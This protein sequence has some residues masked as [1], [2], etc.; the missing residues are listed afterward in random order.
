MSQPPLAK[1]PLTSYQKR[2]LVFLSVATFFEG[3]DF[4][5]LTQI[6][7]NLRDDMNLSKTEAGIM[8]AVINAGTVLAYLLIRRADSWGRKRVLA[9]TIAGYT[10]A[11][12]LSG[13]APEAISFT[14]FQFFARTFL[15]AEWAISMVYAA[16]EYPADRRGM[17][18]GVI[19]A[20]SSLGS[21]MCAGVVPLLLKTTYGWRTVFFVGI[22]PLVLLAFARRNIKET[23]RFQKKAEDAPRKRPSMFA[24][25]KTPYRKRV[26]QLGLIWS[27]TYMCNQSAVTFWKDFAVN[28]RGLSDSDV[29]QA[30]TVAAIA[31]MPM[32]FFS[33]KLLDV[34]G[35]RWGAVIIYSLGAAGTFFAYTVHGQWP[36]TAA[37]VF[38]IF[39]VSATLPVMNAYSTELFPT[40]HRANAFA[41]SNNL[42]GR[43]GYVASPL[44]VG[45][46]ADGTS[47][48]F[49]IQLVCVFPFIA[50]ALIFKM[51][52]ETKGMELEESSA[53]H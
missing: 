46:I 28:E 1:T 18:I 14:F 40:E 9:V 33:G 37:L 48:G 43:L 32:I 52:P 42:L 27:V 50:V 17:V 39:G 34:V 3:Y 20:F 11:T 23:V 5:A 36:L 41:W 35:R 25:F 30:I 7:P 31:S 26:F 4:M 10:I 19:Q 45:A 38:A 21:I 16:E 12:F 51:L 47:W 29:G 53:L 8:L 15:I 24:I 13:L 2:L 6:L 44:L 22:I 49:A